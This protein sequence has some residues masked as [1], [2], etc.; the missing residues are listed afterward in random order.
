M[1]TSYG[2]AG[3]VIII[4]LWIYFSA[5]ILYIGAIFTR[6][7]ALHRGS[8]IYPNSYAVWIEKKEVASKRPQSQDYKWKITG[9]MGNNLLT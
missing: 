6:V 7:Y 1:T 8:Y 5:I 9:K 2:A 4:L 3:S